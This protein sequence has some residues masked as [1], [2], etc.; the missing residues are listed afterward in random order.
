[1]TDRLRFVPCGDR[2]LLIYLGDTID[3]G[4]NDQVHALFHALLQNPHPAVV[5]VTPAYHCVLVEYDPVRIRLDQLEEMILGLAGELDSPAPPAGGRRTV[6]IPVQY[7]GEM[8]PDLATVAAHTGL[9]E[10]EVIRRHSDSLYRVYCLGFSPGF[11]YL[12]GLDPAIAAPRL[13]TPRTKVPGGSVGIAGNQ[14]GV[15]PA[16]SPGGWQLIGRTPAQLFDPLREPPALLEPGDNV[17][18]EPISAARF[19]EL[20]T[21]RQAAPGLP[22]YAEGK[23]G[24]RIIA[25]GMATTLQDLGR[26]GYQRYGVPVGGAADFA[27]LMVGNWL[28]GNRAR[29]CALEITLVGPTVEFTGVVAF[30]LTGAPTPARLIPADGGSPRPV[31][32]WTTLLATPGDRLEVGT[33]TAG[34]RTYLCV[35]GGVD[36]PPVLGSLSED[37]FGKIGPLGRPLQAGDWLPLGLPLQPPAGLAGRTLPDDLRPEYTGTAVVRAVRGPQSGAFTADAFAAFFG[38]EY[39]VG[40]QSDRQGLRLEGGKVTHATGPDIISEPVPPGSIQVPANGQPIL[41]MGNRQTTGGYTKI[42]TAVY[43]DLAGA[44]QLRPGDKL[45]FQEVDQ[46][47]AHAIAWAERRRLAHIRRHLE[48]DMTR[49]TEPE[50]MARLAAIPTAEAEPAP[51]TL[52][53]AEAVPTQPNIRSFRITIGDIEFEATVEED[54]A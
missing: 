34:C 48:R 53:P 11:P 39:T 18:F 26:R 28:L 17:H 37:L 30:C 43:P 32:G 21:V 44:A 22:P 38:G 29:T 8:G 42:A 2:A 50:A 25:P 40:A 15:Y 51:A 12:G 52:Q 46:A 35:A 47:E 33:A 3:P 1:M 4:V 24:L 54:E 45:R 23:T 16:P 14:T 5:E 49:Q 6:T 13:A 7:G 9:A 31:P 10:A 41:L 19:A 27:S 36:L 20:E